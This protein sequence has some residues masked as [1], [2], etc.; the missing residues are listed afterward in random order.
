MR[1]L[2]LWLSFLKYSWM[3]DMEYRTNIVVRVFGE[4]FWYGV[5]LSVFEVLY[6]HADKISGWD[7]HDMRVFMGTLFVSDV[8]YMVLLSENV[9]NMWSIVRRGDLDLYLVKP[10]NAQFMVSFR[11]VSV[12][13]IANF[14][15]CLGYLAWAIANLHQPISAIQILSYSVLILFGVV[16]M[17]A[18]RFMFITVMVAFQDAGQIQFIWHQ[19]HRLA[20]RPDVLYPRYLRFFV[21][22]LFPVGFMASV[23]SRILVEGL[24]PELLIGAP[25]VSL[26]LL[27]L[28][29][30]AW[31]GALKRYSSAS[32]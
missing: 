15:L 8:I 2:R 20:T 9:D 10:V 29:N 3:A 21:L 27:Y 12:S 14:I 22:I 5:Q 23:P 19:L 31:E 16:V 13:Y 28:S 32:S 30:R 7:I 25:V 17:Y 6:L 4:F 24:R 1:Y 26:T 11:K 18:L